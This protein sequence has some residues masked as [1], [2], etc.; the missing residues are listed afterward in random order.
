MNEEELGEEAVRFK[1][2]YEGVKNEIAKVIVGQERVVEASLTALIAGGHV[3][4]EGVPGLGKP[5]W[6][7]PCPKRL[8]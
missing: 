7:G 1:E 2:D 8:I 6:S 5:C 3:L 4:L